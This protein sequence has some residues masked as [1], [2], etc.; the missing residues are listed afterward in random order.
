MTKGIK[1]VYS[2]YVG[3]L[4]TGNGENQITLKWNRKGYKPVLIDLCIS[5]NIENEISLYKGM[6]I[7]NNQDFD[8]GIIQGNME[9]VQQQFAELMNGKI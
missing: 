6:R 4:E 8:R 7:G 1:V 5:N 3:D 9:F 2:Q